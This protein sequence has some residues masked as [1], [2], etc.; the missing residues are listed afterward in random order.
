MRHI[1]YVYAVAM[2][3]LYTFLADDGW[4]IASHIALSSL[5]A[6]FPFLIVLTSLAGFVGSRELADKAAELMLDIWPAQVASTLSGEIHDVLTTT[7]GDA[8]TIG[9]LLALYFASN[10]VES[11]RVALNRAYAVIEVRPWYMLR[12]ESIGYTLV[13]AFTA[14][15]MAFLIVLGPLILA[16]AR[17]YVPLLVEDNQTLLTVARYGI[18]VGALTVALF[19]LHAR[20]PAG[21]RSIKQIVPG[22][23]FTMVASVMSGVGFG[24]YLARFANNYVTMYAGLASVII[25]LVF[26]YF[27]AAIFVY[28]GELNAAI[29]KSRLPDGA[30]LQS[31]QLRARAE[32][33]A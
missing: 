23:V 10:G 22:I 13:A 11:L 14:L 1:R 28:G 24:M 20:L 29:I 4:A 17:H 21:R 32:K 2:D 9:L 19:I 16:T 27:I 33:P 12:L 18:A 30:T 26:L 8:L 6:L 3:A 5:M 7:R 15:A 31:A 25:A